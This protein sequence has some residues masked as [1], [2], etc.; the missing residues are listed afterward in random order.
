MGV[1]CGSRMT[2]TAL[3]N[4]KY[5]DYCCHAVTEHAVEKDPTCLI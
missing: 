3:P 2:K 4:N 5:D 1:P